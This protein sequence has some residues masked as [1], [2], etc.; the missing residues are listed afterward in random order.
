MRGFNSQRQKTFQRNNRA[1]VNQRQL[2]AAALAVTDFT[3]SRIGSMEVQDDVILFPSD[4]EAAEYNRL[5]ER[6]NALAA[7][8]EQIRV[9]TLAA[10]DQHA[11]RT[12]ALKAQH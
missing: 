3:A 10:L 8:E 5:I 9:E 2:F 6:V 7:E 12:R 11:G 1:L 4:G